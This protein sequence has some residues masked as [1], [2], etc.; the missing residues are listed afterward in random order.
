MWGCLNHRSVTCAPGQHDQL[1]QVELCDVRKRGR[2]DLN[3][4]ADCA[5][6]SN[7]PKLLSYISAQALGI[8]RS[9]CQPEILEILVDGDGVIAGRVLSVLPSHW[10]FIIIQLMS[11]ISESLLVSCALQLIPLILLSFLVVTISSAWQQSCLHKTFN[12]SL[13]FSLIFLPL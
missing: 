11:T 2:L 6:A 1:K 8:E 9:H 5:C 7:C 3:L 4:F 13:R 12:Q 10:R